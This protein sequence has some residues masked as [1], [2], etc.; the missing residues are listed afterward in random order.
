MEKERRDRDEYTRQLKDSITVKFNNEI[1]RKELAMLDREAEA[2]ERLKEVEREKKQDIKEK[3]DDL[4]NKIVNTKTRVLTAEEKRREE[5]E[6]Q[7]TA[8]EQKR[9]LI[10]EAKERERLAKTFA[11][12]GDG[13]VTFSQLKAESIQQKKREVDLNFRM[14]AKAELEIKQRAAEHELGKVKKLLDERKL[15]KSINLEAHDICKTRKEKAEA[16]KQE[17]IRKTVEEKQKRY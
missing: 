17:Q 14:K 4:A 11:A 9:K 12:E 16:Y 1:R 15:L 8:N 5:L 6:A 7:M 13:G 2:I 3:A 10:F